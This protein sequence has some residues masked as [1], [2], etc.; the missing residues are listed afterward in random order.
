MVYKKYITKDGK[1]FGPYL[2]E[3]YRDKDGNVKTRYVS[4]PED[5]QKI[6]ARFF[7]LFGIAAF[8]LISLLVAYNFSDNNSSLT[9]LSI[10]DASILGYKNLYSYIYS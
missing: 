8:V 10:I 3:S 5:S 9:G 4:G 2:Y 6:S 7:V 1:R